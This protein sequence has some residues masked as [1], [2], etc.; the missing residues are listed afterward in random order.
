MTYGALS[1]LPVAIRLLTYTQVVGKPEIACPALRT[2]RA[3]PSYTGQPWFGLLLASKYISAEFLEF[4]FA[5]AICI[6]PVTRSQLDSFRQWPHFPARILN[7]IRKL[8]FRKDY[9]REDD[10]EAWSKSKFVDVA[11]MVGQCQAFKKSLGFGRAYTGYAWARDKWWCHARSGESC[12][13]HR[14]T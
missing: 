10:K 4:L 11:R 6:F 9:D 8:R 1:K 7:K 13:Q 5:R 3:V 2:L 14:K 12:C